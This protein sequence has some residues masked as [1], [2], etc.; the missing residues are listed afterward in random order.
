MTSSKDR[1]SWDPPTGI[2]RAQQRRSRVSEETLNDLNTRIAALETQVS[3]LRDNHS[4]TEEI[5]DLQGRIS[6]L[7]A[8]VGRLPSKAFLLIAAV[9][10]LIVA[11]GFSLYQEQIRAILL[12]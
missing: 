6:G 4:M 7:D 2:Q 1:E 11:G 8:K 3:V 5:R 9:C 10:A 12:L